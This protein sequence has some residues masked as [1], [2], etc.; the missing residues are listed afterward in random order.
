MFD[1]NINLFDI[2]HSGQH[3]DASVVEDGELLCQ[4]LLARLDR[5]PR[6][7]LAVRSQTTI[8]WKKKYLSQISDVEC[9]GLKR[10]EGNPS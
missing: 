6:H 9:C 5:S 10:G 7:L 2:V 4:F 8:K 1:A 3:P